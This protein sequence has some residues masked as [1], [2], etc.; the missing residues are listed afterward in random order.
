M[1]LF[2][3]LLAA[4]AAVQAAKIPLQSRVH[5]LN[6]MLGDGKQ[7]RIV[8]GNPAG[9]G[10]FPFYAAVDILTGY[11]C[12]GS[13]ISNRWVLTAGH[14]GVLGGNTDFKVGVGS[15][16]VPSE[17]F[18]ISDGIHV[19]DNYDP[20]TLANDIALI[21]LSSDIIFSDY[22]QAVTLPSIGEEN[23]FEDY[24]AKIVGHGKTSDGAGGVSPYL[25][26]AD[27]SVMSNYDC[28][29]YYGGLIIN[30]MMCAIGN[31][32]QSTCNGDS[33]GPLVVENKLVGV[34]SFVSGYGCNYGLPFGQTRVTSHRQ[35]I[36]NVSGV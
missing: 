1:K 33:G 12:G 9:P 22:V 8:N 19:H 20:W 7:S 30:S 23:Q 25:L 32:G 15:L 34:I 27:V 31:S 24:N 36:F 10:Q 35:W 6:V 11:F 2:L 28:R 29:M 21:H 4:S 3:I 26:Y 16:G 5:P 13:I 18:Y 14:C 17:T